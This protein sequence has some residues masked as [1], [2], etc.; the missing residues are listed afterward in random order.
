MATESKGNGATAAGF[1]YRPDFVNPRIAAE[2][3]A[4]LEA[5]DQWVGVTASESARKVIQYGY[6][7]NY[8]TSDARPM[9]IAP[10]PEAYARLVASIGISFDQL[11]INRY[12]P[13]QGIAPHVDHRDHF[14]P[15]VACITLCSGAEVVFSR[16]P[17]GTTSEQTVKQYVEPGS[18]YMMTGDSRY[19]WRHRIDATKSDLVAG[20]RIRRG[21][22]YSLTFRTMMPAKTESDVPSTL[23]GTPA[24][25]INPE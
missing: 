10:I 25:P 11:I 18:L 3:V 14:G 16:G 9:K 7:Y 4:E 15:I 21:T 1:V 12:L 2:F 5:S 8:T 23:D 6:A 17:I 22:R 19:L 20:N 13:G 24:A